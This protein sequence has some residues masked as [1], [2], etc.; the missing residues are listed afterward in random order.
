MC[1]CCVTRLHAPS[2]LLGVL[3][4]LPSI[5]YFWYGAGFGTWPSFFDSYNYDDEGIVYDEELPILLRNTSMDTNT[6]I[7]TSVNEAWAAPNSLLDLFLES[8]HAGE[9]I[10]HLLKHLLIIA[11]DPRAY[12][13]CMEVHPHCYFLKTKGIDYSSEKVYMSKDYLE[14]V[15]GRNKLQQ[16]ILEL[17]FNFLLTDVDILWFRNPMKYISTT[18]HLTFASDYYF[19]NAKSLRNVANGGFVYVRSCNETVKF[20]KSW[21]QARKKYPEQHDQKV[22]NKVKRDLTSRYHVK[23][24]FIDTAY[25]SGFCQFKTDVKKIC[26]IH[27]NCCIGLG[28]KTADLRNILDDWKRYKS[29]S[30]WQKRK[31]QFRLRAPQCRMR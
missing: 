22:L 7:L 14:M 29:L 20:Y 1:N 26:T 4:T 23:I 6:V 27:A 21:H 17:G 11:M 18:S 25:C 24:R 12:E 2:F 9:E 28:N 10:E 30:F 13:R 5:L 3:L 31:G 8:F 16:R 15:W 19:G